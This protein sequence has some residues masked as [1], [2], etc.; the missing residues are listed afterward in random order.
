M[1]EDELLEK[2]R[3]IKSDL[4][5]PRRGLSEKEKDELLMRIGGPRTCEAIVKAQKT[6][7]LE[8]IPFIFNQLDSQAV[9]DILANDMHDAIQRALQKRRSIS[10]KKGKN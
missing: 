2:I 6:L 10:E 8:R 9:I 3:Q 1:D 5:A 7:P 4:P